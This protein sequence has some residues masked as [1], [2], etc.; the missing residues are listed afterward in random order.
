M[1]PG[2]F[3]RVLVNN[4]HLDLLNHSS[5][6]AQA[7][8]SKAAIIQTVKTTIG[9]LDNSDR[10]PKGQ[11]TIAHGVSILTT[12]RRQHLHLSLRGPE[13]SSSWP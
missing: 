8:K 5:E 13:R 9:V 4:A 2:P 10:M 11:A 3:D 1:L 6:M 7:K 12:R